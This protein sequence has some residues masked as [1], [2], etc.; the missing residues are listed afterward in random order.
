[1][2][3]WLLLASGEV[4]ADDD[5]FQTH[6]RAG[7]EDGVSA[8]APTARSVAATSKDGSR[9]LLPMRF[10]MRAACLSS[11]PRTVKDRRSFAV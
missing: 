2:L 9:G 1:M 7:R 4:W 5:P 10:A 8:S 11:S 6:V 3:G